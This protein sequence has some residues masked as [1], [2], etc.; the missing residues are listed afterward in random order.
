MY[1]LFN[2]IEKLNIFNTL[3]QEKD[4]FKIEF[5]IQKHINFIIPI[6]FQ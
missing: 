3:D 5:F 4:I 2:D 6:A 1:R